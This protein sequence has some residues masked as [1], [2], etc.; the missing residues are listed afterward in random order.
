MNAHARI[1][2]AHAIRGLI[3]ELVCRHD[4]YESGRAAAALAAAEAGRAAFW[5]TAQ[6]HNA[7]A[8]LLVLAAN[9]TGLAAAL[10]AW[11]DPRHPRKT[12]A[13]LLATLVPLNALAALDL[14][15]ARGGPA[16]ARQAAPSAIPDH[17]MP[18]AV[19]SPDATVGSRSP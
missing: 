3:A 6:Y 11:S 8:C 18:A 16:A 15:I 14:T 5:T 17:S 13:A 10:G 12:R 1:S 4:N 2:P 19:P 9:A 7:T